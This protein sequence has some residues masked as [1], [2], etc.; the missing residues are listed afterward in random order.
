MPN[1]LLLEFK[2]LF[3]IVIQLF[4]AIKS[5]G[6][7]LILLIPVGYVGIYRWGVWLLRKLIGLRYRSQQPS[8][9]MT[10]TSVVTPV[11]NE[12]PEIFLMALRSWAVHKPSE[13]IAVIDYTDEK[14]IQAF[15]DFERELA[16]TGATATRLIITKKPGKRPAL[17]DGTLAATGEIVFLVDSDTIWAEDVLVNA[18]A[19][20]EDPE[21]GGVTTR[22]NV[23]N[24]RTMAQRLFDVY[25]DIRYMDEIRFLA[26]LG[27]A[28]TC[29]SGRTAVYRRSAILPVLDELENET[30][31]GNPVISGDDKALTNL[32]QAE[33]W[34][35]R[36]QE[37]CPRLY[38][39]CAAVGLF[40]SNSVYGG[41][42]IVGAPICAHCSAGGS[43]Q[44]QLWPSI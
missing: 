23:L 20:F 7:L 22:Q 42:V 4:D 40:L 38:T 18:I 21:V 10:T 12:N 30:F 2:R 32:V 25:L 39:R 16:T 6:N 3:D 26:V 33:R 24:P 35:V 36:Y 17:V 13:I 5:M 1:E 15:T 14:C 29:I 44:N 41:R 28:V 27:D 37:K 34:K 19:P 9:Y 11:Y 31:W 43:G 8:G